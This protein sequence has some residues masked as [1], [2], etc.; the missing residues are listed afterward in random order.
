MLPTEYYVESCT[1]FDDHYL[2]YH[3]LIENK[4]DNEQVESKS[5]LLAGGFSYTFKNDY[6]FI[7][8]LILLFEITFL[9]NNKWLRI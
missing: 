1:L 9:N 8:W 3:E 4:L 2:S 7:I 6:R 5:Q